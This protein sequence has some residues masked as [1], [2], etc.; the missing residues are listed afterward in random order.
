MAGP[1]QQL[2]AA[3]A[4]HSAASTGNSKH[5]CNW[6]ESTGLC[7]KQFTSAEEL[8]THMKAAHAPSPPS[9]A[10]TPDSKSN[11]KHRFHPYA[12]TMPT[13]PMAPFNPM[14]H[15]MYAQRMMGMPHP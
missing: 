7:G 13:M 11:T 10:T 15:A 3:A 5:T 2:L 9:S 6:V 14:L 1:Y 12:K 8:A 4:A